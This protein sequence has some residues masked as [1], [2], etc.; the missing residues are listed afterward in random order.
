VSRLR[1]GSRGSTLALAQAS[2]VKRQIEE[3]LPELQVELRTIRTSGD[4]FI[5]APIKE[6]GGK[7]IFTKEIEEAL[8]GGEIDL[9]VHSLK[10]LPTQLPAGL[11]LLAVPKRE[12][13]SD[14]LISRSGAKLADLEH[15][16]TIGT[17]SLRRKAQLLAY[18]ADLQIAPL[19]GN[20]DTR[21]KKLD[22]GE[23]DAVVLAAAGLRRIGRDNYITQF[24]PDE[25]CVSAVGQGAL[26]IEARDETD[27]RERLVFLHD[28]QTFAEVAAERAF[29]DRLGSGCHVP[30]GAR[31]RVLGNELKIIA[32]VASLEGQK[33]CRGEIV[34]HVSEAV[35]LGQ[36]LAGRLTSDGAD[37]LLAPFRR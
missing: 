8:T 18:R 17:G 35:E 1:I 30:I 4:R 20:I 7:G 3:H 26:G 27:L 11:T 19:R 16:A 32:V 33:I 9:A 14:V 28:A 10:D 37:K 36:N 21:L 5:D 2:W 25:I 6:I 29:A 13:A 15:R 34:G 23:F 22:N 24:L 31:A 12:D